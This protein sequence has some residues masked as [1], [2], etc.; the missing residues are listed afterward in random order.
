SEEQCRYFE[1]DGKDTICHAT[2]SAT[3]PYV[4]VKTSE[5]GC[6]HGHA[7]HPHDFIDVAG[8]DCNGAACPPGSAPRYR[9][10]DCCTGS[11]ACVFDA[12]VGYDTCVCSGLG[13]TCVTD[14]DCCSPP[15]GTVQCIL[16]SCVHVLPLGTASAVP[17]KCP[18]SMPSSAACQDLT[19][20]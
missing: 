11:G 20:V 6:A 16:G 3:K 19:I 15:A 14:A 2:G 5:Q 8:G 9:T 17:G 13:G 12:A 1:L 18:S 7:G 10:L 4:L